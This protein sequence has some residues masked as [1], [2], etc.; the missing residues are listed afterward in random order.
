MTDQNP[1]VNPDLQSQEE[2]F[3]PPILLLILAGLAF[4]VAIFRF[5][6]QPAFEV[7]GIGA[8]A[9]SII[10]LIAWALM[11]PNQ[12]SD[13]LSGRFLRFGGTSILVTVLLVIALAVVYVLV[14]NANLRVD[15]TQKNEFSL[16]EESR[17][18]MQSL[19]ADPTIPSVRI[20]AFYGSGQAGNR[21]RDSLLFQEYADASGGK[22]SYEFLNPEQNFPLA[23]Q[24]NIT[25]EGA[26]AV[27]PVDTTT[28][29]PDVENAETIN[30]LSQGD[31]TNAILKVAAQGNFAAY[32]LVVQDGA[33]QEMRVIKE[34]LTTRYDWTVRDVSLIELTSP[35]G[36]FR[37]NDP[38][39]DGEVIVIPGGSRPLA[40][41][42]LQILQDYLNGGGDVIIF[43]DNV[44][45]DQGQSLATDPAL[46]DYLF[47]NFGVRL[48][49]DVVVDFTQSFQSPLIPFTT[50]L[51]SQNFI[52]N[53]GIGPN[54]AVVFEAPNTITVAD[55]LPANVTVSR[56]AETGDDS[57]TKTDIAPL[58]TDD[59]SAF[60]AAIQQSDAD[61]S[62]PFVVAAA[63]ENTQSGA[64]LV[65][66]GSLSP[67]L[68]TFANLSGPSNLEVG[69]NS[70]IWTTGFNDFFRT[71]TVQQPQRPQDQPIFVDQGSLSTISLFTQCG[72]PA[73]ILIIGGVVLWNNRERRHES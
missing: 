69:F 71:I 33:H 66:F 3:I 2:P 44:L 54:A 72:L 50:N 27:V 29:E 5:L 56:L 42:E 68:D 36:E 13:L 25:R 14:R 12:V 22:I 46:N 39:R 48:N 8:L 26:I 4:L 20:L 65:I 7:V 11:A 63:V 61:A 19:G 62:G 57:Y 10:L 9:V 23:Q 34:T 16:T 32:F 37:L 28:S 38:V 49:R 17:A 45:N 21:D 58:L 18:A 6:T 67:G 60:Q 35:E 59:T 15:L 1:N 40:P 47:A 41:N 30:F 52:T 73:I 53:N 24:Y 64:H 51:D 70:L 43:A 31:L 55:T